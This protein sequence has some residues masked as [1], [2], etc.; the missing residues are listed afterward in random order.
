[1]SDDK[2]ETFPQQDVR[3]ATPSDEERFLEMINSENTKEQKAALITSA[4]SHLTSEELE[5]LAKRVEA[6][7]LRV[8][9]KAQAEAQTSK[10]ILDLMREAEKIKPGVNTLGAMTLLAKR[11]NERAA[12]YLEQLSGHLEA[13]DLMDRAVAADPYWEKLDDGSYQ[14]LSGA[15]HETPEA[16]MAAYQRNQG[17][18]E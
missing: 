11:G 5:A 13:Q 10:E 12:M 18:A 3:A 1:M 17:K 14:T 9:E 4:F 2:I 15:V 7:C 6:I 16:L 8:A